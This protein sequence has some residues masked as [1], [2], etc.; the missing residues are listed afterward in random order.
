MGDFQ[1]LFSWVNVNI[2]ELMLAS[3]NLSMDL[4]ELVSVVSKSL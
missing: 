1:T 3:L 4:C 2:C